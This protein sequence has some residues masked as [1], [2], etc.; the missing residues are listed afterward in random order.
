MHVARV[1]DVP[2]VLLSRP[3]DLPGS[4]KYVHAAFVPPRNGMMMMMMMIRE[5]PADVSRFRKSRE[6][7]LEWKEE[8]LNKGTT[9][10]SGGLGREEKRRRCEVPGCEGDEC[11]L[12]YGKKDAWG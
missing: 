9:K 6:V 10:R 12:T 4:G 2:V 5:Q 8:E 3:E 11:Y 1:T 7:R